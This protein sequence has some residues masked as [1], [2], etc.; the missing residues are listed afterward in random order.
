M[1]FFKCLWVVFLL[2]LIL[3]LPW[4]KNFFLFNLQSLGSAKYLACK[5]CHI[6]TL[7]WVYLSLSAPFEKINAE[8]SLLLLLNMSSLSYMCLV[9]HCLEMPPTLLLCCLNFRSAVWLNSTQEF[10]TF[11]PSLCWLKYKYPAL[12]EETGFFGTC[13]WV[14]VAVTSGVFSVALEGSKQC[15]GSLNV[16]EPCRV[17]S[18]WICSLASLICK[19]HMLIATA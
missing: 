13:G 3:P 19:S 12:A 9:S 14:L 10:H 8:E 18:T 15:S 1:L 5:L 6:G 7:D 11:P 17:L 4:G 16:F 2:F